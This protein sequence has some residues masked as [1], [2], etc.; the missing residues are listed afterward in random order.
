MIP[1]YRSHTMRRSGQIAHVSEADFYLATNHTTGEPL[2]A[3]LSITID[4]DESVDSRL[5]QERCAA[6]RARLPTELV[7]AFGS[8]IEVEPSPVVQALTALLA[9]D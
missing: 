8:H 6:V 3:V 2:G 1:S 7:V 5:I 4:L 9:T